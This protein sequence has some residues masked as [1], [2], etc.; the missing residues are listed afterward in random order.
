MPNRLDETLTPDPLAWMDAYWRAANHLAVGQTYLCDN[1]L[2]K[3]PLTLGGGKQMSL[4][5]WGKTRGQTS[6]YMHLNRVIKKFDLDMLFV[7]GPGHGSPDGMNLFDRWVDMTVLNNLDRFHRLMHLI[8]RDPRAGVKGV[9]LK[10]VL[11]D[12][13]IEHRQ[14]ICK[15]RQELPELRNLTWGGREAT[16]GAG[17]GA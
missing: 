11:M 1:P 8:D 9:C 16:V 10:Q 2:L 6:I 13:L 14:Y 12:N 7:S 4:G 5:H 17:S 3:R 15:H